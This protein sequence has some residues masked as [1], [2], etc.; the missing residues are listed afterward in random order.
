VMTTAQTIYAILKGPSAKCRSK[1]PWL[2]YEAIGQGLAPISWVRNRA[3]PEAS[4]TNRLTVDEHSMRRR[5]I[6]ERRRSPLRRQLWPLERA[7]FGQVEG[8]GPPSTKRGGP[9]V[10]R[11]DGT[12]CRRHQ[13]SRNSGQDD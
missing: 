8:A 5:A 1:Q 6:P 2:P 3:L 12:Y 10:R 7:S 4:L 11:G 13:N 9:T